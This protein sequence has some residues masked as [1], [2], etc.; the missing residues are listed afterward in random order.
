MLDKKVALVTGAS[1]GIGASVAKKLAA[2]GSFVVV[3]YNGSKERAEGVVDE[4][5]A[6]GGEA[7]A[8]QCDVS[9]FDACGAFIAEIVKTY[10]RLAILVN[11]AGITKD[12]RLM[13]MSESD[14]D[15]GI[16][17]SLKGAFN[18]IRHAG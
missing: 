3:N 2:D 14:F 10:G 18:P 1:R 12:G 4:I 8:M 7:V 15:A 5:R 16:N 11:N 9:D 6:A 17:T 13:K